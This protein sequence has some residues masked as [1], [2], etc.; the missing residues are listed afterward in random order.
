MYN[1]DQ[2]LTSQLHVPNTKEVSQLD[3]HAVTEQKPGTSSA[4]RHH[5][6]N[7]TVHH[8]EVLDECGVQ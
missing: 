4:L 3:N 7:S 6:I 1:R 5:L 8:G 2:I